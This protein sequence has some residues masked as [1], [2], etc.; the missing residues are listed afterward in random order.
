MS[1]STDHNSAHSADS[2]PEHFP[3]QSPLLGESLLVSFPP[4]NYILKFGGS[5]CLI[6][7]PEWV[8]SRVKSTHDICSENTASN[9]P[10]YTY[11]KLN[12]ALKL[13]RHVSATG[14]RRY[15]QLSTQNTL[16]KNRN[17]ACFANVYEHFVRVHPE[18]D[19]HTNPA[20]EVHQRWVGFTDTQT[21][22][23]PGKSRKRNVRSKF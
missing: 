3:L 4:L 11:W 12:Y 2:H 6:W 10:C 17:N 22:M 18:I 9:F 1:P 7:D 21:S 8:I 14:D 23:L 16:W 15:V 19:T 5:S 13:T 20:A